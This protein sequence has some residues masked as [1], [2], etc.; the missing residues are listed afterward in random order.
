MNTENSLRVMK[1]KIMDRRERDLLQT[2]MSR[3]LTDCLGDELK[4]MKK[5]EWFWE[6]VDELIP[7]NNIEEVV[8]Y[9]ER[10]EWKLQGKYPLND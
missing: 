4:H 7:N 2:L 8:K 6:T 9:M 10:I 1:L 3:I 5:S